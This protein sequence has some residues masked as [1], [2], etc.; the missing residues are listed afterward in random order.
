MIDF[1]A[2]VPEFSTLLRVD[3]DYV[4]NWI[5]VL[6]GGGTPKVWQIIIYMLLKKQILP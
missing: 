1:H 6:R 4:H 5:G 3:G 2:G